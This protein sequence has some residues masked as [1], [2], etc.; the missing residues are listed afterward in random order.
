MSDY[1]FI[2]AEMLLLLTGGFAGYVVRGMRAEKYVYGTCG[3]GYGKPARKRRDG[4]VQYLC[5]SHDPNDP[6]RYWCEFNSAWWSSFTP[7]PDQ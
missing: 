6:T 4:L 1:M 7:Y 5:T 3:P 2:L